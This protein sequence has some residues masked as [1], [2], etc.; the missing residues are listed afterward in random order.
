ML[1]AGYV[2][3]TRGAQQSGQRERVVHPAVL[4][5]GQGKGRIADRQERAR[6]LGREGIALQ[7]VQH[8]LSFPA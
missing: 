4:L 6:R 7:A 2:F 1:P 5:A 3:K 8:I